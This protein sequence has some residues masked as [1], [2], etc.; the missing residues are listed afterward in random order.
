MVLVNLEAKC[1]NK[2]IILKFY[3]QWFIIWKGKAYVRNQSANE[4]G[5]YEKSSYVINQRYHYCKC[6]FMNITVTKNFGK[7]AMATL[8][9][10]KE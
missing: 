3:I 10:Q 4:I 6:K 5:T 8:I 9:Q 1:T 2:S 7:T